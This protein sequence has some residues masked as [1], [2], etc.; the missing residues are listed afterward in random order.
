MP[1]LT[2]LRDAVIFTGEAFVENHALIIE[3]GN[4][5]DIVANAKTPADAKAISY[6][7]KILAPGFIDAQV[8][9]GGNVML[10]NTPTS[11]ACLAIAAAHCKYG[12]TN[13]LPTCITDQREVTQKA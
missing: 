13:I 2:A 10:N 8:N 12:T 7:D 5:I 1:S 4:I 11:E 9:G 3:N 6:K